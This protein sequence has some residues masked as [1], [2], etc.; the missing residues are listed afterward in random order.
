MAML[1]RYRVLNAIL[2]LR[3]F[4]VADLAHY[5]G[6]KENTVRTVLGRDTHFV[7]RDGTR[8]QR[9]PGGQPIQYRLRT[10]AEDDLVGILRELEGV[11]ASLPPL[12]AD[13]QDPVT[14]SLVAAEDI[15]LRALPQAP[16]ADRAELVN[17]ATADFEAVEFLA[18][19]DHG[20]A[21]THRRVVDLLLCLAEL[22]Q[23][24]LTLA[25]PNPDTRG[26]DW[27]AQVTEVLSHEAEKKLEALRRQWR[28]L[29]SSWP[30]LSDRELLPDLV[31]RVANSWFGS[32]ILSPDGRAQTT[33]SGPGSSAASHE[34]AIRGRRPDAATGVHLDHR[35]ARAA[36]AKL[37]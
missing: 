22:E 24:V 10:D 35:S 14:L 23:E 13:Q 11:G 2:A 9:R 4:T 15:L 37:R 18:G 16:V 31:C 3:E 6:V 7:E 1:I 29:L 25:A 27:P 8:A 34:Y 19:A 36:R 20:E 33:S 32:V 5:S 26:P 17:L 12:V 28:H 30:A 21:A